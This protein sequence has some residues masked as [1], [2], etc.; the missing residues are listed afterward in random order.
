MMNFFK[1]ISRRFK[2]IFI[3]NPK[4]L[5]KIYPIIY[6][7][8]DKRLN[9]DLHAIEHGR[10]IESLIILNKSRIIVELGVAH[11]SATKYLCEGAKIVN[12]LS[13]QDMKFK[14]SLLDKNKSHVYGFDLWDVHGEKKQYDKIGSKDEVQK[15]LNN[16]GYKN[17]TLTKVDL[18]SIEAKKYFDEF[19]KIDLCFIDGNHSYD[20]V[21]KNFNLVYPKL[22]KTGIIVFDDTIKIDGSREFIIDL[23]TKYNDGT[24]DL[25]T[26]PFGNRDRR[27]G[28]TLLVKR[29]VEKHND[30]LE[31]QIDEIC[32]SISD[33]T[34]IYLKEKNWF[35]KQRKND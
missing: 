7:N 17:F 28:I 15:Y 35:N 32:G 25:I 23:R 20:G 27:V 11:G 19:E 29:S 33:E 12:Q 31:F 14:N 26:F 22:S 13:Q 4:N 30:E 5:E 34:S 8:N 24:F 18:E 3:N 16:L 6:S 1:K 2:N 10:L 9:F 21:K